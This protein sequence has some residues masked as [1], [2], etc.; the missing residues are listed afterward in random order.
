MLVIFD[1]DGTL[2]KTFGI[3]AEAFSRAFADT[4]GVP[5]PTLD[6]TAYRSVTDRGVAEEGALRALGRRATPEEIETMRERFVQALRRALSRHEE[7]LEIPG[8]AAILAAL[9]RE[10]RVAVAT[11]SWEA[12]ARI[13]LAHANIDATGLRISTCDE[14]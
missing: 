8:A 9:G 13:K 11:G 12:S 6:W 5:L 1:I 7:S 3:D 14:E 2:A 4:F 10:G